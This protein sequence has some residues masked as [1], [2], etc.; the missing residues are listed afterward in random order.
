MAKLEDSKKKLLVNKALEAREN[1]YSPY[2]DFCVGAALLCAD[3]EVF[4]GANVENGSYGAT[5]CAERS[6]FCSAIS[7][8]KRK[9]AAIAI[10]GAKRGEQPRELCPPCGICRQFM[11]EFCAAELPVLLYDGQAVT[12]K[13]LEKLLPDA[14]KL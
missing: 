1:A 6:A 7:V 11:S 2:S 12:E 10:V 3:G 13:T 5:I 4:T 14:F 9:F 8:G